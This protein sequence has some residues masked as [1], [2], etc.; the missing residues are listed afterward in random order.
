MGL[1]ILK[2]MGQVVL[3]LFIVSIFTFLLISFIPGDPVF[4]MMGAEVSQA[5]YQR[6][7]LE[8]GLDKPLIMRYFDWLWKA[9]Q[10][11]FG[12]SI[13]FHMSTVDLLL[14]RLP[15]TMYMAFLS[16][17]ISIPFGVFFGVVSAVK[18]GKLVD[19][20]VTLVANICA[21]LP[22]FWLA[23]LV[24]YIFS[25][26]LR[27]LPSFGFVWPWEDFALSMKQTLMPVFCLALNGISSIARQ[28]RSSMLEVI[29]QDYIRT[30][31]SKGLKN[32]TVIV[33]HALKNA[34]I[35]VLTLLGMRLGVLMAGSM[36]V[37]SV[38][39]IPGMGSLMVKSIT[40]R[41]IP[42]VQ[43]CVL[44]TAF[45]TCMANLVTDLLYGVID[46]RIRFEK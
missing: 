40:S 9:L 45:I 12:Q 21:C 6:V 36:F 14:E 16:F 15:V 33:V 34:L 35:P 41:D 30:A 3:I 46:P 1:Y 44:L 5:E 23:V 39:S 2:R 22:Q 4:A 20:V 8:L 28:T 10:G 42:V 38:F 32:I 13:Q 26:Q 7:Y 18:R 27:L 43:V 17:F 31:R 24:M 37:E 11:N 25:L 29:R 19:T